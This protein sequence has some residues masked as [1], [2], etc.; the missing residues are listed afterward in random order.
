MLSREDDARA[1]HRGDVGVA[2]RV[3]VEHR[4]DREDHVR[5][6]DPEPERLRGGDADRVQ[7]RR[8]VRVEHALRQARRAARVAH[9]RGLVLVELGVAPC[10]G[11]DAREQ[12]LVGVLDNEHVLDLRTVAEL[13][14]QRQ[15]RT[16]DDHRAVAG[17][18]RDVADV[19]RVQA[20]VQRVQHKASARDAEVRLEVLVVVPAQRRDPVAAREAELRE[21]DA[22]RTRAAHRVA[23]R[24]P[25]K[26]LVGETRDDFLPAEVR[27][28]A[29][30]DHRHRQLHV[31]HQSVHV[32]SPRDMRCRFSASSALTRWPSRST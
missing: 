15:E 25:V 24:R 10:V 3:R 7:D 28:G 18:I 32:I 12:V 27:L 6:A 31:H 8:A 14:E 4:H 26:R 29:A 22:E 13:L 20:Q 17:V 5:L 9:R 21:R 16:V 2:P 11:V 23:P 1:R 19:V 30:H